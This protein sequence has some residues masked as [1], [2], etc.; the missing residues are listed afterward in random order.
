MGGLQ[1][2]PQRLDSSQ[3]HC[4]S[5]LA[6][7]LLEDAGVVVGND[8]MRT[9]REDDGSAWVDYTS[10]KNERGGRGLDVKTCRHCVIKGLASSSDA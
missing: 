10:L 7:S 5:K 9:R 4:R 3:Q 1:N 2:T 6:D 8:T